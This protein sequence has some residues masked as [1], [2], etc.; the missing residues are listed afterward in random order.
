MGG[1][2]RLLCH[3][4]GPLDGEQAPLLSLLDSCSKSTYSVNLSLHERSGVRARPLPS[5]GNTISP[6]KVKGKEFQGCLGVAV[7]YEHGRR[8]SSA[9]TA[10]DMRCWAAS[11]WC[12]EQVLRR[13]LTLV[14]VDRCTIKDIWAR[15]IWIQQMTDSFFL[16]AVVQRRASKTYFGLKFPL[17]YPASRVS[18]G[19]APPPFLSMLMEVFKFEGIW[20]AELLACKLLFFWVF[21]FFFAGLHSR[22]TS[23]VAQLVLIYLFPVL[24]KA[25]FR[26]V[27]L[28]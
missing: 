12:Q 2:H 10:E 6:I 14:I 27:C 1:G 24:L 7:F 13:H 16:K 5:S 8:N 11:F 18:F 25:G 15:T 17:M 3:R 22:G 21:L 9:V 26:N 4:H 19:S 23:P 20:G 28:V